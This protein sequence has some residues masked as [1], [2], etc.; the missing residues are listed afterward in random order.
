MKSNETTIEIAMEIDQLA[1]LQSTR[2]GVFEQ[3]VDRQ[4]QDAV[5][6]GIRSTITAIGACLT[7][8]SGRRAS[9]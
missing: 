4:P 6:E 5:S 9:P 1:G 7:T 3:M 2:A 8:L